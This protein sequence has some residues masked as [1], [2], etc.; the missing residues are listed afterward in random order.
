MET[1]TW[2]TDFVFVTGSGDI[3]RSVWDGINKG[4][5]RRDHLDDETQS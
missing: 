2:I 4:R 1:T 3:G 5:D